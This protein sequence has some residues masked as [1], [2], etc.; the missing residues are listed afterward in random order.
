M[1]NR[2]LE[3]M[4]SSTWFKKYSAAI[5]GFCLGAYFQARYWRQIRGTLDLWGV[6]RGHYLGA[7]IAIA[8]AAGL[9]WSIALSAVKA[10]R[11]KGWIDK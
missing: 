6:D 10:N 9:A 2:L 8:G 5:G 11:E 7:L 3:W 1:R 4:I